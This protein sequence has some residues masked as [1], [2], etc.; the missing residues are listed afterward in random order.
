KVM[1]LSLPPDFWT[2]LAAIAA[3]FQSLVIIFALLYAVRQTSELR[4]QI[5]LSQI[6]NTY[7]LYHR[8]NETLLKN[9]DLASEVGE[10]RSSAFAAQ[11]LNALQTTFDLKKA[12]LTTDDEWKAD[13]LVIQDYMA[14]ELMWKYW[15]GDS[16]FPPERRAGSRKYYAPDF[17]RVVDC[18]L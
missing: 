13:L 18:A 10:D 2:A 11:V 4:N 15:L 1:S 12:G 16:S 9:E 3:V 6:T 5:R 8:I 14:Y 7:D 17:Q